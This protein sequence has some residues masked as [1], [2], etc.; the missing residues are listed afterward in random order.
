MQRQFLEG[1]DVQDWQNVMYQKYLSN[2]YFYLSLEN[3]DH[4]TDYVTEKFYF[5]LNSSA[6]PIAFGL[7]IKAKSFIDVWQPK[8]NEALFLN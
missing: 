4:C 8:W 3:S 5:A 2:S 7:D 1:S 6:I